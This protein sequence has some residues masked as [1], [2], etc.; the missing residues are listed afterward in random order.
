[1]AYQQSLFINKQINKQIGQ[2]ILADFLQLLFKIGFNIIYICKILK[3]S[4]KLFL[5][6]I[7]IIIEGLISKTD[8][9]IFYIFLQNILLIFY[10]L[11]KYFRRE[12]IILFRVQFLKPFNQVLILND[13]NISII[14]FLINKQ[15]K[16]YQQIFYINGILVVRTP[17]QYFPYLLVKYVS[18]K[19][20]TK[21]QYQRHCSISFIQLQSIIHRK[22]KRNNNQTNVARQVFHKYNQK[23]QDNR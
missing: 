23:D 12:F 13:N 1:M 19:D 10:I 18:Y 16:Q 4:S 14:I 9:N 17:T 11:Q 20:L 2:I 5:K 22:C 7:Y 8:F 15:A 3:K 21:F 6:R